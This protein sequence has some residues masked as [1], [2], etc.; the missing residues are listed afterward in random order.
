MIALSKAF[1]CVMGGP[2]LK[3]VDPAIFTLRYFT[4]CLDCG[5]CRDACCDHGVDIDLGNVQRLKA[6]PDDFRD[7][8]GAPPRDWFTGDTVADPEFPGGVHLRTSVRDGS[9]IFRNPAGRGCV[10]HAYC[11]ERGL[12]YHHYK[13]MVS[14]LF[15]VTFEQGLLTVSS[16]AADG[17][18]I[19]SGQGPSLYD[20]ARGELGYYFG[21]DFIAELDGLK[22]HHG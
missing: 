8:I 10:I 22:A 17:S 21:T 7:R 16:E 3:A 13:P 14:A 1:P 4:R 6:L 5:F 2:L 12:D 9:C 19:C 11:L 15:P 18:L 20:G